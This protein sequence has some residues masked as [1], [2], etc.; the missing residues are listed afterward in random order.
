MIKDALTKAD[1]EKCKE[2]YTGSLIIVYWYAIVA[3][4]IKCSGNRAFAHSRWLFYC[5]RC[6]E[7]NPCFLFRMF[8]FNVDAARHVLQ[9][10]SNV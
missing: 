1:F 2:R 9:C 8:Q 7:R 10:L 5:F 6:M 3:S 4:C